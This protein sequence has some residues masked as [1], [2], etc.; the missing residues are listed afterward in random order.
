MLTEVKLS[1]V[2]VTR[3]ENIQYLRKVLRI[4]HTLFFESKIAVKLYMFNESMF[5]DYRVSRKYWRT[6]TIVEDVNL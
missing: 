3:E 4:R 6:Q 1:L 2:V 5:A